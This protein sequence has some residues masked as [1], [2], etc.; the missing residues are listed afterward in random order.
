MNDVRTFMRELGEM[1]VSYTEY[2][3]MLNQ[4]ISDTRHNLE[5]HT[6]KLAEAKMEYRA[7]LAEKVS[8]DKAV[9]EHLA[10]FKV[11]TIIR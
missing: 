6:T 2:E 1:V 11:E 7:A 8:F 4:K 3:K 9:D 5:Y 10:S